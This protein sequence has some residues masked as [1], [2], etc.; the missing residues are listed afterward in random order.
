MVGESGKSHTS[1]PCHP[2]KG[3]ISR[4]ISAIVFLLLKRIPNAA[5]NS[6]HYLNS[7]SSPEDLSALQEGR[8]FHIHADWGGARGRIPGGS[9]VCNASMQRWARSPWCGGRINKDRAGSHHDHP[10]CLPDFPGPENHLTHLLK[11]DL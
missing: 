1:L 11:I 6:I 2:Q 10:E 9:Q 3:Q 8:R 5:E 7:C 4:S